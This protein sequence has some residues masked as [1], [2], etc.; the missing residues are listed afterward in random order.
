M[1]Y[2]HSQSFSIGVGTG[3]GG[4]G[5]RGRSPLQ[6]YSWGAGISFRPH[7]FAMELRSNFDVYANVTSNSIMCG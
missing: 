7:L 5:Q 2:F 3:G 4:G 6:P 1:S